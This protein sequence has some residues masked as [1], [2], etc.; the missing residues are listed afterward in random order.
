M[1]LEY[2]RPGAFLN[3]V[4]IPLDPTTDGRIVVIGFHDQSLAAVAGAAGRSQQCADRECEKKRAKNWDGHGVSPKS[5]KGR[6][7]RDQN[8]KSHAACPASASQRGCKHGRLMVFPEK[9]CDFGSA[10]ANFG[11]RRGPILCFRAYNSSGAL[12]F[13]HLDQARCR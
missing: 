6:A 3:R 1:R 13:S 7:A 2:F 10:I 5:R 9:G 11:W 8:T 4:H 12:T